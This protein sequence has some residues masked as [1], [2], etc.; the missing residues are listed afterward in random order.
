MEGNQ[1]Q[2]HRIFKSTD[3]HASKAGTRVEYF[4][5][6]SSAGRPPRHPRNPLVNF[7]HRKVRLFNKEIPTWAIVVFALSI[8]IIICI[9]ISLTVFNSPGEAN[10]SND[11]DAAAQYDEE[12]QED[13]NTPATLNDQANEALKSSGLEAFLT[14][15]QSALDSAQDD[16][17][18]ATVYLERSENLFSHYLETNDDSYKDQALQDAITA[19]DLNHSAL[20]ANNL[21]TIYYAIDDDANG[22]F[23]YKLYEDRYAMENPNPPSEEE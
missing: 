12:E 3:I 21:A 22:D 5:Q 9:I 4:K 14:T 15:Y 10:D 7:F 18:K 19:E 1:G 11:L 13:P 2:T 8:L 23:Y 17:I 16:D 6:K 20:T